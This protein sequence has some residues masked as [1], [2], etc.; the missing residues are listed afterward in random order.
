MNEAGIE[1]KY[2]GAGRD[3]TPTWITNRHGV[4]SC[5]HR[6]IAEMFIAKRPGWAYA[7]PDDVP[8]KKAYPLGQSLTD[9]GLKRRVAI[10]SLEKTALEAG[11][12]ENAIKTG[13][14]DN[15][16]AM[17]YKELQALAAKADIKS[18]GVPKEDLLKQLKEINNK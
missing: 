10:L 16:D 11:L 15:F 14:T 9:E 17:T 6:Y 2:D 8:E 12:T 18:V 4:K 7:E 1:K 13:D 5:T 3:I